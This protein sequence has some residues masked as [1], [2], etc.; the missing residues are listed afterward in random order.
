MLCATCYGLASAH[1]AK[2]AVAGPWSHALQERAARVAFLRRRRPGSSSLHPLLSP[3]PR[4]DHRHHLREGGRLLSR[5]AAPAAGAQL[6]TPSPASLSRSGLL[7]FQATQAVR[8]EQHGDEEVSR[9]SVRPAAQADA[10]RAPCPPPPGVHH[11]TD[12][13]C[14][15]PLLTDVPRH[16][17]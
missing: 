5:G 4:P 3:Q 13:V 7:L 2:Q 15:R 8:P 17:S 16:S 11:E 9:P 14:W 1:G 12:C 10:T 6:A